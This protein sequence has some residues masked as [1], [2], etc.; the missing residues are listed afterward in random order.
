MKDLGAWRA[1]RKRQL[2]ELLADFDLRY[3]EVRAAKAGRSVAG[4]PSEHLIPL[5]AAAVSIRTSAW[6]T[7]FEGAQQ[8][9]QAIVRLERLFRNE[10][11][12]IRR[13]QPW[14]TELREPVAADEPG[15]YPAEREMRAQ[16]LENE[17]WFRRLFAQIVA[18]DEQGQYVP[19]QTDRK[20]GRTAFSKT[21]GLLK[22]EAA[23]FSLRDRELLA[24]MAHADRQLV[25][26]LPELLQR[27]QRSI[28]DARAI[29]ERPEQTADGRI[30]KSRASKGARAE[31]AAEHIG[32][33]DGRDLVRSLVELCL[34][35]YLACDHHVIGLLIDYPRSSA[36]HLR[37][38]VLKPLIVKT[39][40]RKAANAERW[41]LD[42]AALQDVASQHAL[43]ILPV[44]EHW[45]GE[46]PDP[47]AKST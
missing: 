40:E 27:V 28:D 32:H 43:P 21:L 25:E 2:D 7:E 5:E 18:G 24:A 12:H 41:R 11:D 19:S 31:R 6:F 39:A 1:L 20:A 3:G 26:A 29:V 13:T 30:V 22:K 42:I 9:N 8:V 35:T 10:V 37:P 44:I 47:E 33:M 36:G 4:L 17:L 23:L 45:W 14:L 46:P 38:N 16:L 15:S 34:K